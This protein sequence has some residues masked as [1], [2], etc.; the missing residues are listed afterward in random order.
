MTPS[1]SIALLPLPNPRPLDKRSVLP[2]FQ[3][4]VLQ[5]AVAPFPLP[6]LPYRAKGSATKKG[7]DYISRLEDSIRWRYPAKASAGLFGSRW[8]FNPAA[9]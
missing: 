2:D 7:S 9:S 3:V 4:P 8:L 6:K 1:I 5:A